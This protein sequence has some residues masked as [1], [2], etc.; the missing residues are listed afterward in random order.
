ML[1]Q[2]DKCVAKA[3]FTVFWPGQTTMQCPAHTIQL[4]GL[5]DSIGLELT[6]MPLIDI[7]EVPEDG[8][9]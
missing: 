3:E 1:C 5:A 6:I 2:Q 7:D 8:T 4:Q 9:N